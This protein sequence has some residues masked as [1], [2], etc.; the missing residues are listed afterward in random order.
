MISLEYEGLVVYWSLLWPL[1]LEAGVRFPLADTF[2]FFYS[3]EKI[4][5]PEESLAIRHQDGAFEFS[6]SLI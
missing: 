3:C 4:L 6:Q 1:T 2:I 5:S